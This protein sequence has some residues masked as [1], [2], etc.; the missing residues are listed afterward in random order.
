MLKASSVLGN[1]QRLD[2]GAMFGNAPRALW[3]RWLAPDD[4]GRIPLACRTLLLDDGARK[5]LFETGIGTFFP[6]ELRDRYGVLESEHVLLKS[7]A[8]L[9]IRDSDIDVVVLSHLHFDHA[10]GLLAPFREGKKAE[11]LFPRARFVV[12]RTAF[13]R[14]EH[15]HL[16][17]HASYI[18][19]LQPLLRESGR[20]ELIEPSTKLGSLLGERV[21][22]VETTGHTPGMLHAR[23]N[24]ERAR[25]FFAADLVPGR[26]WV[27]LPITMGYDRYPEHLVDEKSALFAAFA[28][29]GEYLFY[30]HDPEVSASRV[31]ESSGRYKPKD[32]LGTFRD[33]DLDALSAPA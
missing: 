11:L 18:P 21:E 24:G 10:G 27:H 4:A 26:A 15:P 2:G 3:S 9:G 12:G 5:I 16:R 8:E 14:A 6:P 32:E 23:I 13:E 30:T 31:V 1:S 20:L 33:W 29:R 17:D 19:A 25:L 28:E 7:L 22:F